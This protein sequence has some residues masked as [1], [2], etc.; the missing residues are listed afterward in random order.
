M[1]GSPVS[2]QPLSCN[3]SQVVAGVGSNRLIQP[4]TLVVRFKLNSLF[5]ILQV[6][7]VTFLIGKNVIKLREIQNKL[8]DAF[9][10]TTF[11]KNLVQFSTDFGSFPVTNLSHSIES[12]CANV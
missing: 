9:N 11:D 4:E 8:T 3:T 7:N 5:E 10:S 6:N 2:P 1:V 12:S